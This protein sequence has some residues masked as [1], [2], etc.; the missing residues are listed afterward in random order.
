VLDVIINKPF[1]AHFWQL[2]ND[3]LLKRNLH[4]LQAE[5]LKKSSIITILGYW[6]LT[7]WR[8]EISSETTVAGFKKCCIFSILYGAE[9]DFLWQDAEYENDESDCEEENK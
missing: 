1:K 9:D 3:W 6:I 2:Y 4:S 7:T 5:K 8:M